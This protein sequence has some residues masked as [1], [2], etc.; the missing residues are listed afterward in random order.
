[1]TTKLDY[2]TA[3][4]RKLLQ[5]GA[6]EFLKREIAPIVGECEKSITPSPGT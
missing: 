5:E 3:S 6:K 4:Q 1:M 2:G